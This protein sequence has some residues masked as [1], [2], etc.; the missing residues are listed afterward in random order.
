MPGMMEK[1]AELLVGAKNRAAPNGTKNGGGGSSPGS[2]GNFFEP[3][4][5]GGGGG[6]S[7]DEHDVG[8]RV[9]ADYQARIPDFDPGKYIDIYLKYICNLISLM[10]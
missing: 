7:G 3:E 9:G 8:M 5:G 10:F 1:G 6:D 4:S 2:N